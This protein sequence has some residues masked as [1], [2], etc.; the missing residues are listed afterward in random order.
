[1][2]RTDNVRLF[3]YICGMEYKKLKL[4]DHTV[5][6]CISKKRTLRIHHYE[7]GIFEFDQLCDVDEHTLNEWINIYDEIS[8]STRS[9]FLDKLN[10][11]YEYGSKFIG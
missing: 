5:Y 7:D 11:L 2:S 10:E 9:E 3:L 8:E 6:L 1:M 4:G